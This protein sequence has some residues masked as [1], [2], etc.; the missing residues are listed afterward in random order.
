MKKILL[1]LVI[2]TI[3]C[4]SSKRHILNLTNSC[5][6]CPS[7]GGVGN[8]RSKVLLNEDS[9]FVYLQHFYTGRGKWELSSNKKFILI[10]CALFY[11]EKVYNEFFKVFEVKRYWWRNIDL[12]LKIKNND[13]LFAKGEGFYKR[14]DDCK[15]IGTENRML[16]PASADL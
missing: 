4:S 16:S 3:G 10:K 9:T 1:I 12:K 8:I 13:I 5:F 6:V 2:C 7:G 11:E 15:N 14:I